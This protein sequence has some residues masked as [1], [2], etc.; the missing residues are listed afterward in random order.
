ML[1]AG[2]TASGKSGLALAVAKARD[3]VIV[4]ADSMQV[5]EGL[6]V[7]TARPGAEEAARVPHR[8]YGHVDPATRF[9][10]G[11]WLRDVENL[12]Q[13]AQVLNQELVFVGGTGLYFEA[14]TKGV[15]AVPQVSPE[16][17]QAV[18]ALVT[19]MD[20]TARC[21]FLAEED[22]G[23]VQRLA[24]PDPQR[25]IRAVSVKRATGR[26]LAD[27]QRDG[28]GAQ[29]LLDS[30]R[31]ECVV[32]D[33]GREAVRNNID[34]RF[35]QMLEQGA[36]SEA[37]HFLARGLAA[38]LPAM[39]AIGLRELGAYMAG[40]ASLDEARAQAVTTS[41]QYAKRQRTWFRNRMAD[42][43]WCSSKEAACRFLDVP[44]KDMNNHT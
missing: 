42:W 25:V 12:I 31:L 4:N 23:M 35:A 5:Y 29:P 30:Y 20:R 40:K 9:S 43:Q 26:S 32:L 10:V 8:L 6:Q 33:P 27:W 38:D 3:G 1:I 39:K 11:S 41:R 36:V 28:Q 14:L 13:E 22:P 17:E 21:A 16:I 15:G 7:L 37:E 18:A 34:I 24:E 2:P 44:L 19:P